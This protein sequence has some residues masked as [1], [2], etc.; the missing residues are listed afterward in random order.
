M[1]FT[2]INLSFLDR[3]SIVKH[4]LKSPKKTTLTVSSKIRV[5]SYLK[6]NISWNFMKLLTT[7]VFQNTSGQLFQDILP[8]SELNFTST[9]DTRP[10]LQNDFLEY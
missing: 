10:F 6:Q 7:N 9:L 8:F 3:K 5:S 4:F 2:S 1:L